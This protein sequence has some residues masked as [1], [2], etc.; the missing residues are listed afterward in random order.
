MVIGNLCI[1]THDEGELK[2]YSSLYGEILTDGVDLL[3]D[4]NHLNIAKGS[5]FSDLG[6]GTG[7][8]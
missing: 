7:K 2:G 3:F 8:V 6:M 1:E 5:K 4:E